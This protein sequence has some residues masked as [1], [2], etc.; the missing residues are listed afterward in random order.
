MTIAGRFW[1]IGHSVLPASAF[2][3]L[4]TAERIERIADVRRFPV[5]RRHPQFDAGV[6]AQALEAAG[7]GYLHLPELGGRREAHADS[8][9]TGWR[10]AGL[11][12][13][14]D[15]MQ[16]S[17]FAAGMA[18]LLASG[19]DK[20]IAILCAEKDW[21]NCHRGLISDWLKLRGFDVI[22]VQEPGSTEGHPYT[23]P[24]RVRNGVLSYAADTPAQA[25][26]DL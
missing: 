11:R 2:I 20:R 6:M 21:R 24:A 13:Y 10:E 26:L 5:S 3:A 16:T 25:R 14:A 4:L 17:T 18:R 22:H 15:Y 1:T 23:K 7:I 12:G 9:N 19:A 8:P